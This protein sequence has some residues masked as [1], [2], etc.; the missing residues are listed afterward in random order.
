MHKSNFIYT[1][2]LIAL[3]MAVATFLVIAKF[4]FPHV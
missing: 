1:L 2:I 3:L 4:T